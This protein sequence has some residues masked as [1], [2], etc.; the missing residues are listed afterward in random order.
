[1]HAQAADD[2]TC[3]VERVQ[4]AAEGSSA[5]VVIALSRPPTYDVRVL[6]GDATTKTARRLV[7]D[8]RNTTLAPD[9]AKAVEVG[10]SLLRQIRT[11]QFDARTARIVLELGSETTHSVDA[12]ASPPRV[13]IALAGPTTVGTPPATGAAETNAAAASETSNATAAAT[14]GASP[15]QPVRTIPIRAR[16]HR[17]YSL[18]Y[19]R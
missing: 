7:L 13:T 15:K 14:S 17:P 18:N 16:G 4:L 1:V 9:A 12:S 19:G 5:K 3:R 8:F 6:D 10:S 2:T 11:G